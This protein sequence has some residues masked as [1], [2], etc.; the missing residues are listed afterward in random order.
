MDTAIQRRTENLA[1]VITAMVRDIIMEKHLVTEETV[2]GMLREAVERFNC[3]NWANDVERVR[4]VVD[5]QVKKTLG[6]AIDEILSKPELSNEEAK[7]PS[8][9]SRGW[10]P[11]TDQEDAMLMADWKGL[12]SL[13]S[14]KHGRTQGAI[15]TRIG[16][17]MFYT[18]WRF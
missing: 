1:G 6:Q 13:I 18:D 16:R 3:N 8:K 14:K 5:D 15:I 12:V 2:G 17:K 4:F 11:W 10:T 9:P 7:K